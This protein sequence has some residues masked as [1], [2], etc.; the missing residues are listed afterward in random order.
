LPDGSP[1]RRLLLLRGVLLAVALTLSSFSPESALVEPDEREMRG[2]FVS[3][4]QESVV[5]Q[6]QL[7]DPKCNLSTKGCS[8]RLLDM[9]RDYRLAGFKKRVCRPAGDTAFGVPLRGKGDLRLLHTGQ[10]QP[11][12]ADLYCDPLYN[13]TSTYTAQFNYQAPGWVVQKFVQG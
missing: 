10:A 2:A 8:V 7:V 11:Q 4:L 12:V 3:F 1:P 5:S 13:K 9:R 6:G